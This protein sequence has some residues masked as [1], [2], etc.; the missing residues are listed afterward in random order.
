MRYDDFT[1]RVFAARDGGYDV[2]VDSPEGSA[3]A[4][5]RL[6]PGLRVSAERLGRRP[7][8][9]RGAGTREAE[10]DQDADASAVEIGSALFESLFTGNVAR[11]Y[12][13][14]SA[15]LKDPEAGLRIRLHLNFDDPDIAGLAQI[16]WEYVY[17]KESMEHLALSRQT[18]II[19]YVDVPRRPSLLPF[20]G[21]LRVLVVMSSPRGTHPLDLGKERS[22]IESTWANDEKVHVDFLE[23]PTADALFA[24]LV[25]RKYHVLH[26]MGHGAYDER[27]GM[28]ALVLETDDGAPEPLGADT[29]GT[30]L[31]DAPTLR[32]AFLN[33]CDTGR[34]DKDEPF[35]GVATRLVMAGLPAVV[36]MQFPISDGAAINFARAFYGHIA[37]GYG[38]DHAS[39]EGR[40]AILT[41]DQQS[42]EWGIP[43]VYMRA[44]DGRLFDT[45]VPDSGGAGWRR[46]IVRGAAAAALVALAVVAA[47]ALWPKTD[48]GNANRF[49]DTDGDGLSD[50]REIEIGTS[51]EVN[52]SDADGFLDFDE[53]VTKAF[54]ADNDNYQFNP[55]VADVPSVA[56]RLTSTPAVFMRYTDSSGTVKTVGLESMQELSTETASVISGANSYAIEQSHT[57]AAAESVG[58]RLAE[59]LK[60][61]VTASYDYSHSTSSESTLSWSQEQA[62]AKTDAATEIE[63]MEKT[64]GVEW[65]GGRILFTAVLENTGRIACTVKD[66]ALAAY[67]LDPQSEIRNPVSNLVAEGGFASQTILP[68]ES[69]G[70]LTFSADI[71]LA[72][73]KGLLADASGLVVS[74]PRLELLDVNGKAFAH[75]STTMGARTARVIVDY[76]VR[77]PKGVS[78]ASETYRV[79]AV[80]A[81]SGGVPVRT[82]FKDILRLGYETGT[83]SWRGLGDSDATESH[84]GLVGVRGVEMDAEETAYWLVAHTHKTDS[85]AR[86]ET[87]MMN[88]TQEGY[89]FD[90]ISLRP[91]DVLH[92]VRISDADRDGLPERSEFRYGTD[93]N[94]PD[95]DG[96]GLTDLFEV[97]GWDITVDGAKKRVRTNPLLKD[98]DRDKLTDK[99]E[100]DLRAENSDPTIMNNVPPVIDAITPTVHGVDVTLSVSLHDPDNDDQVTTAEIDWGNGKTSHEVNAAMKVLTVTRRYTTL[101]THRVS[102][103]CRDSHGET[104]AREIE[105]TTARPTD[106]L[107]AHYPLEGPFTGKDSKDKDRYN[108]VEDMMGSYHATHSLISRAAP[109]RGEAVWAPDSVF[110]RAVEGNGTCL[111]ID[112]SNHGVIMTRDNVPFGA[113]GAD[114]TIVMWLRLSEATPAGIAGQDGFAGLSYSSRK[115]IGFGRFDG[116]GVGD[117]SAV[118][119]ESFP[120]KTWQLVAGVAKGTTLTVFTGDEKGLKSKSTTIGSKLT[121][122]GVCKF[123]IGGEPKD[124]CDPSNDEVSEVDGYN[125][126]G[127]FDEVRIFARALTEGEILALGTPLPRP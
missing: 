103:R 57:A 53:V 118:W 85:G 79:A 45:P 98:T 100:Y 19:R 117:D 10:L 70:P 60:T 51:H 42:A 20:D 9:I 32:L 73:A 99:Q 59:G 81:G 121:N 75:N 80:T 93:P 104:A 35:S 39:A 82:V 16:P 8:I 63:A 88:L 95:T 68:G 13:R 106:K 102:V 89:E 112:G 110:T 116:G 52:D 17:E 123:I 115:G 29:L 109:R 64:E 124:L 58:A 76:G 74:S 47:V 30:W 107:L 105:V 31:R 1:I 50:E 65:L 12:D 71:D 2:G 36:A 7:R 86:T 101:G 14:S 28:G 48:F 125:H 83:R 11:L 69:I 78:F 44:P 18:P 5:V 62:R 24:R 126:P 15:A 3:R 66:L 56:V 108:L 6:P 92:L 96:D 41:S 40:K 94:R 72:T 23:H 113:G 34:S 67:T 87:K 49:A 111:T 122:P 26:Y 38:V 54:N 33:A 25:E 119:S 120:L 114:F 21:V 77:P 46:G 43:V 27:R 90:G 4:Y 91:G 84:P 37:A 97:Y 22:L 127:T 55:R 61:E